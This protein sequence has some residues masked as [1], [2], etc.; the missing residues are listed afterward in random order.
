MS[1][2][3]PAVTVSIVIPCRDHAAALAR[4]LASLRA[5]TAEP[6]VETIV[7]DSSDDRSAVEAAKAFP[8]V[9]LVKSPTPLR[10]GPARNR[11]AEVAKGKYLLFVDADCTVEGEWLREAVGQLRQ[12]RR[13]VGGPVLHG[14]PWHPVAVIDNLMQFLSLGPEQPAGTV[15]LLPSC[16]FCI[17][18]ADFEET[19][20][21]P[22]LE[23]PAGE[24]VL[25]FAEAR[26]RWPGALC[27]HPGMRVRHFGRSGW[28]AFLAHQASF[29]YIRAFY[30]LETK[31]I[32]L[33]WGRHRWMLPAI[34][35]RRLFFLYSRALSYPRSLVYLL[36]L[37]PVLLAGVAAWSAGFHKGCKAR[38]GQ[39]RPN[40][41]PH[42]SDEPAKASAA[43]RDRR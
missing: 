24:D 27:F 19:P 32:H 1:G 26:R 18:K 25:F 29:G 16:N 13:I 22:T 10:P 3:D 8:G 23:H 11:G 34:A 43:V 37:F 33:D 7:V 15:Q 12:G 39:A 28:A 35:M 17:G 14:Q 6:S 5:Q 30:A 21:F 31:A 42:D 4:C 20:G 38:A 36:L 41:S 9:V 2:T 40:V